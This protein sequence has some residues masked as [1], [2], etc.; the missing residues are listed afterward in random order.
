M[1]KLIY[2][3]IEAFV[4]A[5][6]GAFFYALPFVIVVWLLAMVLGGPIPHM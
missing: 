6:V 2:E 1:F 5:N 3:L 4:V